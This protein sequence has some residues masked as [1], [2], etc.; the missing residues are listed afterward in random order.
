MV[1][2]VTF[3]FYFELSTLPNLQDVGL[4]RSFKMLSN[5]KRIP[6]CKEYAEIAAC[7]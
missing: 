3:C 2:Q 7:I 4:L 1:A 6:L 5:K